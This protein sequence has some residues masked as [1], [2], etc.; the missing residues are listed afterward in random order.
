LISPKPAARYGVPWFVREAGADEGRIPTK[1]EEPTMSTRCNIHFVNTNDVGGGIVANIYRH[2]DGDPNNVDRDLT[3]FF[4]TVEAH[5][6]DTRFHDPSYLA[7][8]FVVWQADENTTTR[9]KMDFTGVGIMNE[10]AGDAAYIYT[11]DCTSAVW[12]P[13]I[14]WREN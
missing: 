5:T 1:H 9:H 10:D 7:A 2:Y 8:K 3:R 12:F 14:S 11:V 4:K 6:T 13:K